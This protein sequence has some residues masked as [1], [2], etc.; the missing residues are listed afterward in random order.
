MFTKQHLL[1]LN[2]QIVPPPT[3]K[4]TIEQWHLNNQAR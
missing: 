1:T 3:Q 2:E 4:F